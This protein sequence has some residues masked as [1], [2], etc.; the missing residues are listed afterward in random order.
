MN[1][2][3][4]TIEIPLSCQFDNFQGSKQCEF[5]GCNNNSIYKS[6]QTVGK[7]TTFECGGSSGSNYVYFCGDC[8]YNHLNYITEAPVD[9]NKINYTFYD[10]KHVTISGGNKIPTV[11][12][13]K[14]IY[15]F[16]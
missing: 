16:N 12:K 6:I 10:P 14:R 4:K 11:G 2:E 9:A 1:I 3:Q 15:S 8:Y 5:L 7:S 13:Y